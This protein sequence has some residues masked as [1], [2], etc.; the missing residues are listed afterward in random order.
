MDYRLII[1]VFT[2]A[3]VSVAFCQTRQYYFVSTSKTWTDA[4]SH[5]RNVFTDLATIEN[6]AD[7]YAVTSI[8]PN[9]GKAWIGLHDDL[10][11]SW[12]W[13]L[14]DSSFYGVGEAAFRNWYPGSPNNLN[15][16]QQY[17]VALLSGSPYNGE[18]DDRYCGN[19]Y[20]F[21][22]YNGTING[23]ASFVK[24][25]STV[26]W[27]DAQSFCRNNY[28]DLA[29]IR[30][31]TENQ[32]IAVL[33]NGVFVWI[34]LYRQKVWSDGT[35]YLFQ[36]WASGQPDS[37]N[38]RCVAADFSDSGRWSDELCSNNFPSICFTTMM[39]RLTGQTKSSITLQWIKISNN[40]GF[41]LQFNGTETNISAPAGNGPVIHT[42]SSLTAGTQY[43]FTLYSVFENVRSSGVSITAVTAPLNTDSFMSIAQNETSI[44]L[45]WNKVNSNVSF[46]L[47]FNGTETSISAPAGN[48]PVNHT[49]SSL[50]AGTQYTFTLYSVFENV[51]S[52]GVSIT[53]VT[54]VDCINSQCFDPC[55]NYTAL[56]ND[57]RSTNNTNIQDLHCDRN[58]DWQGWYRLFLGQS[59]ARI[60]ERCIDS[61]RCGT[62]APLW[63]TQPHPTQVGEIVNRTVCNTW[64]GSCC[65]FNSHT[66]KVKLCYGNYYVYKLEKPVTCYLA[67]CAEANG[68]DPE[69]PST[70]MS[71]APSNAQ[72][73]ISSGQ[74]ETS[75]TLQWNKVNNNVSYV[76]QFNGTETNISAPAGNGP[77]N[78]TVSSLTAGTQYTFTL[79][80]VFE[81]VRSSGLSITAVTS[82]S[83]AQNLISSGQNETSITL[84]WNKVNNNVSFVLQFNGTETNISAPAGNGPV[85]HTVSSLTAGTQYTFTL[86]SVFEN[87]RSSGV[88]ITAVTAPSNAQNLISSGQTETSITLQWNK[89]NN[90]V[91]FLLQFN[92]T[93]TSISAPAGNGPVIYTVSSLTAGTQYTFTLYSVFENVRSSGVSI[94]AVT[95]PSNAQNLISSGQN[96][97]SITLQWNKVNNNVSFVLQF[98][99][100]ETSISAPAGNGPV[101]HTVSSLTAGT[102]YTFT[103]YSV[104]ENVRSSGVSITAV[105]APSNAQNLISSGQNE[106]SITLQW[107]KVNNNVSFVLQFNGTETSISAPAGN[108]PVTHTVS[109]L[110]AGTQ[111]TFTLYSVFENVRSSGVNIT[112]VTAPSNAQNLISSGQNET[113]ITLQWNKVN[114]NVSFVLQFNGTETEISAPAG[115]GPLNQTV[116]SLT[117]GTQYTFTLYSVF[118]N[119]RSSGVNI[120]AVTAP[121]NAQ[122]L[123]SSGQTE[124]SITLQWNKVNNNV[125]FVLQFNG[126]ETSI[127]APAGNGPVIHT[128]SSLTAGTQYTFTLYSVFE[129][130]RSRGVNIT[131]VTA[132][133]N[134]QNLISSGQNETSITLQWNKVNNNVNFVLQFNGTET[135][136]SAPAGNGPVTHTVSSL[137]AG[138]QYT[139]TLY[140]V[141]ENVR[142]SGVNITAVTAPSNAQNLIS[143]GQNETSITLQ[144]NKVNNNVSF[145]LQFNGTETS[146]SAPAGNGPVTHTVSSLTAGTQYT[147]TL[148]SVFENV[149]SS[150]VS[151]TAV[152]APLNA[153]NLI[154]SG[155][156]ETSITLQ[157]NKVNNNVNFV[158]QFNGTET[159][160]SAPAGNGP[161][162][163]TVSSLTA[164]TQ[165]TFTLY[166]VFENV[167]SSGVNITAV[168]APS[169]AQNLISSGQ[170]ETSIT[171]Q[172]NKVNNNVNFVLQFNG[173]ETSISAPAGNGPLNQTV[174]SLTA[175]TQYTFTLYSV[176]ENV[177]SSG[178]S[179]TAVT[180]PS[181]AQNLISSGQTET[182]IT[183]Q[184]NKVN[185][186]VSFVLQFNGTET[187]I[188]APAGNGPLNQTVSSLTAGTQYTFT[189]Y[190]VFENI[191]SSGVSITAVTAPSNAQNL[192]SSGQTETSITLQWNKV[193][194]NVSFVLQFNGTETSISAPAGNGPVIHT[195]SSLTAGTQYTFTLYSVFEN[196][197]SRGV[198]ITAVTAPSNA[199]NLISSGQNETSITLQWNKVNNNVSFVLQFNGTE[200]SISAP[201]GN[202]PVTH[203]VS[204]LTAGTQY[205]FTLYSVFENIRSSGVS[206]T[207]VTAPSNAQNLISSGQNETSITL[208]WNKVNNNVSFVL[209][210]N[211][212][213][214]SISAP[215]GNGPVITLSHLSLLELNT[216]SLSTLCLRT[217]EAVESALLQSLLLQMHKTSYHQDKQKPASLCSGIKSTT[218][219]ALFSSLMVQRQASVHQLEMDQ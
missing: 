205:T 4:Q 168:T 109:S 209:Q 72:N 123:I 60:P 75:I 64:L 187:S 51:R 133:S 71:P 184:W 87:V 214:T 114:N 93:E 156:N 78:H 3:L 142:S 204:S 54:G 143:S 153:Q 138:T 151:I 200:T 118:E 30:N 188:S 110:T 119:V 111:Y 94:T 34:G 67:Y 140:S 131:A 1:L 22:C 173:T 208:Q 175:G 8:A 163:Q 15:G 144:W 134:A 83:N 190:S 44:T 53:A 146:I 59:S 96:E 55:Q 195:I 154:S 101:T 161:L 107:N 122:N 196:I 63:V 193:N 32:K 31:Q 27:T 125:S 166:S 167:R 29:S 160:I 33:A 12:R 219:S 20:S 141:F 85:T 47:Q 136:I 97:T 36:Y 98:N 92:V 38:E 17:C 35:D 121:S 61:N 174:S 10:Q 6:T 24:V 177:R 171:L 162:N 52:S 206:I 215:A 2:G 62:H 170:N 178:V 90:N 139:F 112:A 135:S 201:A 127:S 192:I 46:V 210:F 9:T 104:F 103:L 159:S 68:T 181:N 183:L 216:H 198:N 207:A 150:G 7:L 145:L 95:A 65:Y 73:L 105:T 129:N 5:C 70:T 155:Q 48:G 88:S 169:N 40:V 194:N 157:W 176:F 13:S 212:T 182:S 18:W 116:S 21:V 128:V 186:N 148:Y 218:M 11:N 100:T 43:T 126:T 23:E 180:A 217:S 115:N 37:G 76:L 120:T 49:V 45:Q 152:T 42:V 132:P 69:V 16:Q 84:Q 164:G 89:V 58:I 102:Q 25:N 124:T 79:Y 66:I 191:R 41:I 28:V 26:N 197:R 56:N 86:Y 203:T 202:G 99:G 158:L 57:W 147:F 185:N 106:T 91:S 130:I 199:Q 179:I 14:N 165:Y 108:G 50:T 19:N 82:P 213:E 39:F 172:W 189:L 80:S 211:G 113:S 77:L 149:R 74:N 81:N 137:T 117:A